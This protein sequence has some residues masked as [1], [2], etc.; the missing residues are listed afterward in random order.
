MN[1]N[2]VNLNEDSFEEY[3][4]ID[5][6]SI[7]QGQ[8]GQETD[9]EGDQ[10]WTPQEAESAYEQAGDDDCNKGQIQSIC[11]ISV[12]CIIFTVIVI[13]FT[14][15]SMQRGINNLWTSRTLKDS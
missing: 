1:D 15:L 2:E 3:M 7:E 10:D 8:K 12:I 5:E 9:E 13:T 6:E 14:V 11:T 4:N